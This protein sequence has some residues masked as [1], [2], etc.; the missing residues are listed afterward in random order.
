M[1]I[2]G[3]R[4][5]IRGLGA[6]LITVAALV[7]TA[8]S[9]GAGG[10]GGGDD[11]IDIVA[12]VA[13][14]SSPVAMLLGVEQ[15]FFE[16]EG[17][18]VT[19][20]PAATGAAGVTQ[21]INGQVQVALGGLSGTVTAVDQGIPVAFVSGGVADHEDE[22]GTQYQTLVAG[23]S[24]IESFSDLEGKTVAVNS[25]KCCWELWMREAVENDGGDQKNVEFVQL[26]FADGVT[27]LRSGE[28][29]AI[30]TLQ[31]F[32]TQLRNDG[33]R[34]IGDS[35]ASAFGDPDASNTMYF[36]ARPFVEK[37]P[38]VVER[39]RAALKKSADY[40]DEHPDETRAKIAEQT[41]TDLA[42]LEGVPLP[43]YVSELDT[44]AV[45]A[46]AGFLVKY[47]VIDE[48]PALDELIIE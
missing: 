18:N 12:G 26:A 24:D 9:G 17:L 3:K 2:T 43:E 44:D 48:A 20:T 10:G 33:F 15:G 32:A 34:D 19:T 30:S 1:T 29:D 47:G 4:S 13:P 25:L 22:N 39:W 46:E 23:D 27:A 21:L 40:A 35:A 42:D 38:E 11:T 8:C 37:N 14:S 6:A 41:K 36:M 7:T 31:P 45:E 28:V 5:R 16:E